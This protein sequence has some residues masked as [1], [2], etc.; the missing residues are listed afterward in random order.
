MDIVKEMENAGYM[1]MPEEATPEMI[2]SGQ[3]ATADSK[4]SRVQM[5]AEPRYLKSLFDNLVKHRPE[6]CRP[7]APQPTPY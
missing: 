3:R 2:A 5:G 7:T 4:D 6:T 1:I